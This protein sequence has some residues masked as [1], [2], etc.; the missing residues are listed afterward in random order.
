MAEGVAG[1]VWPPM[2]M[3]DPSSLALQQQ[4]LARY[5][6]RL[7]RSTLTEGGTLRLP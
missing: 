5:G 6:E 4:V 1:R 2:V 3:V 7:Q